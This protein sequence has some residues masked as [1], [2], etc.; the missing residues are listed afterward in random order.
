MSDYNYYHQLSVSHEQISE[1]SLRTLPCQE[2]GDYG[3]DIRRVTVLSCVLFCFFK[4][5]INRRVHRPSF[6]DQ[7]LGM[8]F[9]LRLFVFQNA[10]PTLQHILHWGRLLFPSS[11]SSFLHFPA[12]PPAA[13]DDRPKIAFYTMCEHLGQLTG[14]DHGWR[15]L[16]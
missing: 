6:S 11:F 1:L 2:V 10:I 7:M 9:M 15:H 8:G 12:A 16:T 13:L 4:K 5:K 14:V 3:P